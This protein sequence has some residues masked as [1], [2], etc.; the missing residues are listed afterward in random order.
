MRKARK[1]T[2]FRNRVVPSVT[3][4]ECRSL[5]SPISAPY[6]GQAPPNTGGA[7]HDTVS[8]TTGLVSDG[9]A[10]YSITVTGLA[11]KTIQ[12]WVVGQ[13]GGGIYV[14]GGALPSGVNQGWAA[15]LQHIGSDVNLYFE[16]TVANTVNT[17]YNVVIGYTDGTQEYLYGVK[18]DQNHLFNPGLRMPG[19]AAG[20]LERPAGGGG[21]DGPRP[22]RRPRWDRG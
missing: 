5:L 2:A 1:M 4:L 22:G 8:F 12:Y 7:P 19:A 15:D 10:D 3:P 21:L 18:P 17:A 9:I 14:T 13:E 16:P 11:N 20:E 6:I